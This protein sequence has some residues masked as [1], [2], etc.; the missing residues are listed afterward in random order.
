MKHIAIEKT[1]LTV[2][3]LVRMAEVEPVL[4]TRSGVPVVSM[5]GMKEADREIWSL[6][7]NPEFLSLIERSRARGRREGGT[8]LAEARRQLGTRRKTTRPAKRSV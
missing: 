8:T 7:N 2:Q 3:Q 4:L 1:E 6:G 5:I